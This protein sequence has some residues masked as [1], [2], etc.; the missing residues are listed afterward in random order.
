MLTKQENMICEVARWATVFGIR[1]IAK[2]ALSP[3][4]NFSYK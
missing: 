2:S 3:N 1:I 4:K